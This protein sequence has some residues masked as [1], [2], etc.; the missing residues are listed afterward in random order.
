MLSSENGCYQ[1]NKKKRKR[2]KKWKWGLVAFKSQKKN[3][4]RVSI[5]LLGGG[6]HQD[7]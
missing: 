7:D 5:W 3:M 1:L 4:M 2:K 6:K